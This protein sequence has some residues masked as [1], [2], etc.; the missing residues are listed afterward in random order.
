MRTAALSDIDANAGGFGKRLN[1]SRCR[2]YVLPVVE[3]QRLRVGGL[4]KTHRPSAENGSRAK[5]GSVAQQA[6]AFQFN[7]GKM[8]PEILGRNQRNTTR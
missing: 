7:H 4:G 1:E 6:A 5:H 3:R 8:T 2:S